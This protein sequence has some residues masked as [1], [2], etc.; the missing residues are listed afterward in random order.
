MAKCV[1]TGKSTMS[2]NRRSHAVNAT[3]RKWKV[4]L[5]TIRVRLEDGTT[6]KIR[7][8]ARGLKKHNLDRA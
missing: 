6:K 7:V 1:I 5:Q 3:R 8:S 2:G 4:N